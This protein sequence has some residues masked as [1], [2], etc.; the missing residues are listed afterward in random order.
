MVFLVIF[1]QS[2]NFLFTFSHHA[3]S[4]V[5]VLFIIVYC[6][7]LQVKDLQLRIKSQD[8]AVEEKELFNKKEVKMQIIS[9]LF[10]DQG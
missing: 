2:Q 9:L 8:Q 7:F 5:N 4:L 1:A 3:K 10:S 6:Y